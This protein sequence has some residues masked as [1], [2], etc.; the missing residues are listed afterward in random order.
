MNTV[1]LCTCITALFLMLISNSS[2]QDRPPLPQGLAE[3]PGMTSGAPALPPGLVPDDAL[4]L[5]EGLGDEQIPAGTVLSGAKAGPL[6]P[7]N[8]TGYWELRGGLRIYNDPH[9]KQAPKKASRCAVVQGRSSVGQLHMPPVWTRRG[10]RGPPR[11][12][13]GEALH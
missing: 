12:S 9:E 10:L 5:P 13:K 4:S 3:P 1:T 6:L 11:H 2:A 8:L 7:F